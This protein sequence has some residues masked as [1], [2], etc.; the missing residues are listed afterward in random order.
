MGGGFTNACICQNVCPIKDCF[1][2]PA[3][4]HVSDCSLILARWE[5]LCCV[6]QLKLFPDRHNMIG[7]V[8]KRQKMLCVI[9]SNIKDY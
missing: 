1:V 4:D 8:Y 3:P 9:F 7:Q 6:S 2:L 5:M